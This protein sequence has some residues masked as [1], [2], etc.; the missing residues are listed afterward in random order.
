V[1]EAWARPSRVPR[2]LAG[3]GAVDR[4]A[5]ASRGTALAGLLAEALPEPLSGRRINVPAAFRTQ[6]LTHHDVI[7]MADRFVAAFPDRERPILALG[8][9]TAG[10]YFAPLLCA[11]LK[12]R[13]YRKVEAATLRPKKR[14]G[15]LREGR[16]RA[17]REQQGPGV[18]VDEPPNTGATLAR[19]G[20]LLAQAGVPPQSTV[21]LLPVHPT[22]RDWHEAYE[23]LPLLRANVI[24]LE[25][26][27][28]RSTGGSTR[29]P[30]PADAGVL[31]SARVRRGR[32]VAQSRGGPLQPASA[33]PLGGKVPQPAQ[34]GC[35]RCGFETGRGGPRRASSWP[36]AW[37]GAG[38]AITPSWPPRGS[39]SS[40]PPLLGLRDASST[41]SGCRRAALRP[42]PMI[43]M[44]WCSAPRSY[45]AA[46]VKRLGLPTDPLPEL[47]RH[48]QKGL[49]LLAGELSRASDRSTGRRGL[50]RVRLRRGAGTPGL[51]GPYPHRRED[52]LAGVGPTPES[53]VKT[54]FEHHGMGKTALNVTIRPTTSP[55]CPCIS[56]SRRPRSRC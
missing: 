28:W 36:R 22:R 42:C 46:R 48:Q 43:A 37:A 38:W 7:A 32:G 5:M 12:L 24:T 31:R 9:R 53:F 33:A 34:A 56:A 50:K 35:T 45:V 15:A 40:C 16:A 17:L 18:V 52:A 8:L 41:S 39:P 25:P 54:D 14:V 49:V 6:D 2:D 11:S 1:A 44:R 3:D 13:G 20:D 30:S 55:R 10:S 47:G 21:V 27:R 51:S 4:A 29:S 19:T 23:C 26:E